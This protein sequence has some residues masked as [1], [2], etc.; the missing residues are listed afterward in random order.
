[1]DASMTVFPGGDDCV[2]PTYE[3][4]E[5][6]LLTSW[7]RHCPEEVKKYLIE[8]KCI[9][10]LKENEDTFSELQIETYNVVIPEQFDV[11]D[12]AKIEENIVDEY[13]KK[14]NNEQ[15][16][17]EIK[18]LK[19]FTKDLLK[20]NNGNIQENNIIDKEKYIK[21]NDRM[22]YYKIYENAC[23]GGKNDAIIDDTLI[24]IKTRTRRQ[25]VRR[26]DY[27][28]YQLV[29]YLM[30]MNI[31]RG[32]IVQIFN[33]E[34]FDSDIANEEEY[35]LI[36]I[37]EEPW[38]EMCIEIKEGLTVYFKE[39]EELISLSNFKYLNSV[40]PKK[41]R[42]IA[43][44]IVEE[45]NVSNESNESNESNVSNESNEIVNEYSKKRKI[46][47]FCDEN[48]KFKNLIRHLSK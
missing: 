14:R 17:K 7:A 45:S 10:S 6:T 2:T 29:C 26:N 30:A 13:K 3:T 1:M 40:I 19:E 36:D 18:Q 31:N 37:T 22:Y 5:K 11:K 35:G 47:T 33:K 24:E 42:P 8:N 46:I 38:N 32:K 20:K 39:L 28:L 41:I 15:S 21:G 34:K 9:I 44:F 48:I 12:F 23:I 43:K 25:N 27:D 4:R 16:D